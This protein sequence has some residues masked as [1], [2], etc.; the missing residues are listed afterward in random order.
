MNAIAA[1]S[2]DLDGTLY[3]LE[4]IKG[5]ML[6][7]TFPR[8]RTMRVGKRV[9]DELRSQA[10][11]DGAALV[12]AENRLAAER[13]DRTEAQAATDLARVFHTDLTAVL[14]RRGPRA[15]ARAVI[16]DVVAR[17]LKIA[18]ISDRGHIAEKLKALGLADLPW[19]ALIAADDVGAMKPDPRPYHVCADAL[20]ISVAA[21]LHVG[22]RADVDTA[23]AIAAGAEGLTLD[24]RHATPLEA[25]TRRLASPQS[26]PPSPPPSR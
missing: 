8:W 1:V 16:D 18:V 25:L 21:L 7:A 4:A 24:V 20:G 10:F 5:P 15:E 2:F 9:R 3:A 26:P 13:L 17:G 19:A 23:G 12:A 14:R 22:D 11:V 6:W